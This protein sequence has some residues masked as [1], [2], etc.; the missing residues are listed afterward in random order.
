METSDTITYEQIEAKHLEAF[1]CFETLKKLNDAQKIWFKYLLEGHLFASES[2][3][4][5]RI[6]QYTRAI[7][8]FYRLHGRKC[9][10]YENLVTR[11]IMF[12]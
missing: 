2:E 7:G 4:K 12:L 1:R 8:Y 5:L 3:I 10:E 9:M 11:H 6:S